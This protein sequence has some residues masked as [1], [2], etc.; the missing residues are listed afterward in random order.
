MLIPVSCHVE[1]SM[2][3][4]PSGRYTVKKFNGS[5][6]LFSPP[7][8]N[9]N[10]WGYNVLIICVLT[11]AEN[12]LVAAGGE[13]TNFLGLPHPASRRTFAIGK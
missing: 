6:A 10:L 7:T 8:G 2:V 4:S 9:T 1:G 12:K 11:A 13:N 3:L 5:W